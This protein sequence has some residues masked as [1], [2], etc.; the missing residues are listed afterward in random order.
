MNALATA[1]PAMVAM[2]PE[3]GISHLASAGM[4]AG[5]V[6]AGRGLKQIINSPAYYNALMGREGEPVTNWLLQR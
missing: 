6:A 4:F 5:T 2:S 1:G 3:A